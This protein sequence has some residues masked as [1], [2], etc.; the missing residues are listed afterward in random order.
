MSLLLNWWQ[1]FIMVLMI[2]RVIAIMNLMIEWV[3]VE[4]INI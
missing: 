4:M 1:L 3:R 2:C